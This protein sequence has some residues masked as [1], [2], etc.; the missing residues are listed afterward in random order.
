MAVDER[1]RPPP[2]IVRGSGERLL[3]AVEEA[4]RRAVVGDDLVLDA[5]VRQRLRE[6]GV[7]L[8]RDPAV[9]ARLQREDRRL[10]LRDPLDA[11]GPPR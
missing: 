9:V 1:Q 8:G 2:G 11:L 10:D 5:C 4:V 6:G 3:L 7:V